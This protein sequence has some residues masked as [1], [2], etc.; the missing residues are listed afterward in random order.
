MNYHLQ[1]ISFKKYSLIL[2]Y[3]FFS[4]VLIIGCMEFYF[5][6]LYGDLTRIGNFPERDFGW[7]SPQPAIPSEQFKDY[8]L[9]EADIL[10]IGDS[11]SVSRNWQTRLIA[12]GLKLSTIEWKDLKTAETLPSDLGETLRASG[13]KGRY[14]IIESVERLFQSRMQLLA[15]N[16]HPIIKKDIVINSSFPLYPFTQREHFSLDKPNGGKWG[17]KTLYNKIKLSLELAD[18]YLKSD[19]VQAVKFD[20][21]QL[22]SHKLCSYALFI[23]GDFKKETFN[24]VANVL[25]INKNLLAVDIQPIWAVIPDKSTVYLGYGKLNQYPYQNI[26]TLFAQYPELTAPDLGELFIQKSRTMKD[27]YM[28]NDTHLSTHG[29]LS[30][31]DLM[32]N[33]L[34]KVQANQTKPL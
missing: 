17:F 15:K 19:A 33:E 21:C 34:R 24:S 30:L 12:D 16:S 2:I 18:N 22:F 31:G 20:G 26:W 9:A 3:A 11:F 28:P 27:F 10:V 5:Q 32:L 8:S 13:F 7:Q 14:V 6:R 29:F 4:I 1:V 23:D 25:T